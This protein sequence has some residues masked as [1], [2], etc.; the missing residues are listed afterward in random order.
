M[1]IYLTEG[2]LSIVAHRDKPNHLL[3]RSRHPDA[4]ERTFRDAEMYFIQDA[5]YPYRADILREDMIDFLTLRL[6]VMNYH[7]FKNTV[8][9]ED[10][11]RLLTDVWFTHF[12]WGKEYREWFR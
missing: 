3:V 2:A 11:S 6:K 4:I 10:Y 9:D 12:Q 5:D 1:W 7:N 8:D